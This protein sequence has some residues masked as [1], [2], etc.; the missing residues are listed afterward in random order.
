MA[1]STPD[2]AATYPAL[3]AFFA[4]QFDP[5]WSM[6]FE[7][8][9]DAARDYMFRQDTP[10]MQA[11]LRELTALNHLMASDAALDAL[12]RDGLK[13]HADFSVVGGSNNWVRW[14]VLQVRNHLG[15]ELAGLAFGR[16]PAGTL[17]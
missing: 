17:H 4:N 14:L 3:A 12:L 15:D 1:M 10:T 5:Q 7:R 11:I 16:P 13:C 6:R 9:Q 2:A 8:W